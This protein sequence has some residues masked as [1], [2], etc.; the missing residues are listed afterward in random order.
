[1]VEITLPIVLQV[2]QTVSIA[3]GIFYYLYIMR[4]VHKSRQRES[5]LKIPNL[6]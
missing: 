2:I 5:L 4:N 6:R 3:V 1:M